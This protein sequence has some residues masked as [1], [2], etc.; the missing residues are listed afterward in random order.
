MSSTIPEFLFCKYT[1]SRYKKGCDVYF[2]TIKG[3]LYCGNFVIDCK[4]TKLF[5][6]LGKT[7]LGL[8]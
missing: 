7:A 6:V 5:K 3:L 2:V 1:H 8:Q 4:D